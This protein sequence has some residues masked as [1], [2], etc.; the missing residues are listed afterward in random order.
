MCT[1]SQ[2]PVT[3]QRFHI[4][5]EIGN[6]LQTLLT[7]K[8]RGP[9]KLTCV[10]IL[11]PACVIGTRALISGDQRRGDRSKESG[12]KRITKPPRPRG[13]GIPR[14]CVGKDC[15]RIVS[16]QNLVLHDKHVR[17]PKRNCV[18]D[19]VRKRRLTD[20][21]SQGRT[22]TD[23]NSQGMTACST[24]PNEAPRQ[25]PSTD[26]SSQDMKTCST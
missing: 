15:D 1:K 19:L 7:R 14:T 20:T 10:F 22:A 25:A 6:A 24:S 2:R 12:G 13:T 23:T 11:C 8:A 3:D 18:L 21:R 9:L 4:Q 26:T 16:S 17:R 5:I